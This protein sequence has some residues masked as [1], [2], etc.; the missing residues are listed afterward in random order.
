MYH[1]AAARDGTN[2]AVHTSASKHFFIS[3]TAEAV[4]N[5][6]IEKAII[7]VPS[8]G[9]PRRNQQ[10]ADMMYEALPVTSIMLKGEVRKITI[11]FT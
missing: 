6:S 11:S 2:A 9:I 7:E 8:H 1:G 5:M 4:G 3:R 10:Q